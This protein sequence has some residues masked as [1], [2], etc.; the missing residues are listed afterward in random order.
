MW[1]WRK[2]G[3][4]CGAERKFFWRKPT[5]SWGLGQWAEQQGLRI[6]RP[7]LCLVHLPQNGKGENEITSPTLVFPVLGP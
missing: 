7:Q 6:K 2:C 4:I 1:Q 5:T 3:V